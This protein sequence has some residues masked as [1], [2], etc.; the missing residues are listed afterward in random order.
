MKPDSLRTLILNFAPMLES[1]S[2]YLKPDR[3]TAPRAVYTSWWGPI[4]RGLTVEETAKHYKAMGKA[5][6]LYIYLIVHAN[7][8]TGILF[9]MLPV[10]AKDM[11]IPL[12]T[13]RAWVLILRR[14]GYITTQTNGRGLTITIL[15]WKPLRKS[16][17]AEN[18]RNQGARQL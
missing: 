9:R 14:R 8:K 16:L 13:V 7:R 3:F 18:E 4:W 11:G 2:Q 6:W 15:K 5:L 12:R 1:I 10:I 17:N